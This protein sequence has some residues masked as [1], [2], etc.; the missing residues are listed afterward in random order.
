MKGFT[1]KLQPLACQV[2]KKN[3]M[4]NEVIDKTNYGTLIN[5]MDWKNDNKIKHPPQD[6]V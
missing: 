5:F 1:F 6:N 4:E 3:S 2:A